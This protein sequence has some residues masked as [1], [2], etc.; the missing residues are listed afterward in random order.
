MTTR[1][2][3]ASTLISSLPR[4]ARSSV[5]GTELENFCELREAEQDM[6]VC[7]LLP[8]FEQMRLF[9]GY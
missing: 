4:V 3:L 9:L 6:V 5:P 8:K 7:K 1:R 2:D